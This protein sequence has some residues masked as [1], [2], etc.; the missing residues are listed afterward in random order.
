MDFRKILVFIGFT[1]EKNKQL[2][3]VKQLY[4]GHIFTLLCGS[5]IYILFRTSN[6]KMFIWFDELKILDIINSLRSFTV[7]Y[8]SHLPNIILYSLPDGL[9]M[10]SYVSLVLFLWKNEI[11]NENLFWI[12]IIPIISIISELG[13]LIK[14]VPGTFDSSDLLMYFLGTTLPFIIYRKS[15]TINLIH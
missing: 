10:F 2:M 11:K 7:S 3:K 13:Q 8:S 12:L 5:L 6:L 9:W 14:I 1:F 4:I 15:I